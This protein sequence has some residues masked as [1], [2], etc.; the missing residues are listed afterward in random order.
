MTLSI[1]YSNFKISSSYKIPESLHQVLYSA[2]Q[3]HYEE[4]YEEEADG[5]INLETTLSEILDALGVETIFYVMIVT[6]VWH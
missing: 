2:W 1:D 5:S 6:S 4:L 3:N